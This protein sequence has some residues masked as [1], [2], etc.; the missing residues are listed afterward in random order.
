MA[1]ALSA[2]GHA[3]RTRATAPP[4]R[5]WWW[6]KAPLAHSAHRA[7]A[8]RGETACDY[9]AHHR[10]SPSRAAPAHPTRRASPSTA[11][12]ACDSEPLGARG[13]PH[14]VTR[15]VSIPEVGTSGRRARHGRGERY[16]P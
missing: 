14:A 13:I 2:V 10:R 3:L 4:G 1:R 6:Y 16:T 15:L 7:R 9:P 12:V 11:R 8:G 5:E